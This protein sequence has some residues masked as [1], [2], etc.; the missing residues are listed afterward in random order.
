[1]DVN[2]LTIEWKEEDGTITVKELDKFVLSKGAWATVMFLY[3]NLNKATGEYQEP[4][5][6]IVRYKKNKD[7]YAQQ[8]K[9][10]ISSKKQAMMIRDQ[11]NKWYEEEE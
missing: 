1:M 7:Y 6:R 2:D 11:L 9:F 5:V 10:N 8:S 4:Q 3:Q